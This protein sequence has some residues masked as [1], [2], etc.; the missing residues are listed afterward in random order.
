MC[1]QDAC[2]SLYVGREFGTPTPAADQNIPK[3][4]EELGLDLES[5]DDDALE[6]ENELGVVSVNGTP[7]KEREK[8]ES[9]HIFPTFMASCDLMR[10]CRRIL[11]VV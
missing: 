8:R 10:I 3:G 11:D 9:T 6:D 5:W 4:E 2:W 7:G 1:S